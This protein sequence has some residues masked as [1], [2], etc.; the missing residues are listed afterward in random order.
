VPRTRRVLQQA[1]CRSA[2][3]P[4]RRARPCGAARLSMCGAWGGD[5]CAHTPPRAAAVGG[6]N[7]VSQK[8]EFTRTLSL[9]PRAQTAS[10]GRK[11]VEVGGAERGRPPPTQPPPSSAKGATTQLGVRQRRGDSSRDARSS[12]AE[13]SLNNNGRSRRQD[14]GPTDRAP[15]LEDA[16]L[17]LELAVECQWQGQSPPPGSQPHSRRQERVQSLISTLTRHT[18]PVLIVTRDA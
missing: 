15:V 10:H 1:C 5:G 14:T 4:P 11:W 18:S 17:L 6:H 7:L 9:R 2:C 3:A 12:F 16:A 13:S 8:D